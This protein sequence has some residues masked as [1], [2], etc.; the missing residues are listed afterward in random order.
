MM[1]C[2]AGGVILAISFLHILPK[3]VEMQLSVMTGAN[4]EHAGHRLPRIHKNST[5]ATPAKKKKNLVDSQGISRCPT[6]FSS[7]AIASYC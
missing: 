1:D 6:Y 3:A 5:I 4:D 2:F 7:L